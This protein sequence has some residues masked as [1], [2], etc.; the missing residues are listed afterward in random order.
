ME[1]PE[2][3]LQGKME[4]I[5]VSRELMPAGKPNF[6]EVIKYPMIKDLVKSEGSNKMLKLLV[7][8]V[9]DFCN[10]INVVR[11]MNEDQMIE[12]ASMLLDECDNFRLEDYVMMFSL[13]KRGELIKILDHLDI[14]YIAMMM[15]EYW[16]RRKNAGRHALEDPVNRLDS[17]GNTTTNVDTMNPQDVKLSKAADSLA[18]MISDMKKQLTNDMK[19]ISEEVAREQLQRPKVSYTYGTQEDGGKGFIKSDG[20]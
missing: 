14:S 9:K 16:Q 13:S 1:V 2:K 17:L 7:L 11:N 20:E 15:N 8:M 6:L 10:S 12:A 18:G 5:A 3:K 4:M 19:V